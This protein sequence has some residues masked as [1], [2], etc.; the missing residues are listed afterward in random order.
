MTITS[1]DITIIHSTGTRTPVFCI[2]DLK[3]FPSAKNAAK[4]YNV[5]PG[6]ISWAITGRAKTCKGKRFCTV[7][8]MPYYAEEIA[9]A[10]RILGEKATNYDNIIAEQERVRKIHE[11]HEIRKAE[12]IKAFR[13]FEEAQKL[14]AESEAEI[15]ALEGA[16]N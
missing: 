15:K 7:S 11:T 2:T 14:L 12:Y 4:A 13:E 3:W 9:E 1:N 16:T 10:S 5:S 6:A 8:D